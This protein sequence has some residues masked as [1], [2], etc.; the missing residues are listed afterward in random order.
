MCFNPVQP[1]PF[2]SRAGQ[3]SGRYSFGHN[4]PAAA[5]REVFKPSTDSESLF[6]PTQKNFFSGLGTP[7]GDVTSWGVLAFLW[8]TWPGPRRQSNEPIFWFSFFWKLDYHPR[9]SSISVAKIMAQKPK[10]NQ[11]FYPHKL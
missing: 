8:P 5:A 3:Y 4:S 9:L 10:S 2:N 7:L 11:N 6:V 1:E